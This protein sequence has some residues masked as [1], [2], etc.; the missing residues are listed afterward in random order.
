MRQG[1]LE[2]A[3][4]VGTSH[5]FVGAFQSSLPS[6]KTIPLYIQQWVNRA[7]RIVFE[8]TPISVQAKPVLISYGRPILILCDIVGLAENVTRVRFE[9]HGKDMYLLVNKEELEALRFASM[10]Q[11]II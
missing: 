7:G 6:D 3:A 2:F 11:Q 10:T 1:K 4:R 8:P 5:E 9:E